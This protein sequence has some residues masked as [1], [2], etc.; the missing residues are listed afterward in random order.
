LLHDGGNEDRVIVLAISN[1]TGQ[2]EEFKIGAAHADIKDP[3]AFAAAKASAL[4]SARSFGDDKSVVLCA[5]AGHTENWTIV[6]TIA[7]DNNENHNFHIHQM[8]FEVRDV[9]DPTGRI[10]PPLSGATARRMVDS[11]PVPVGGSLRIGIGFNKRQT[12]GRFVFHCHILE[13]EDKGMMAE[14]EVVDP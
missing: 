10:A 5:H 9:I 2:L 6:N 4:A 8:K 1:P 3:V 12:G 7:A 14:I 13:H 11:Y